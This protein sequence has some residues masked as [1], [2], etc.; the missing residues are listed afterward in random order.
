MKW[1]SS[2]L[3]NRSQICSISGSLSEPLQLCKGVPQGSILGPI[4]F[5]LYINNLPLT[6]SHVNVDI[7]ADDSTLWKYGSS[8]IQIQDDLQS[9]LNRAEAWF[10]LN[11]MVPNAKKTK[12]LLIG[13]HQKLHH[14]NMPSLELYMGKNLIAQAIDEKL[15][16]VML[17]QHFCWGNHIDYLLRKLNSR[18]F[19]LRRAK[20]YLTISCRIL[21]YNTLVKP[22]ILEYLTISR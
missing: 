9:S 13:T 1:F 12:L 5:S 16:G 17:D 7:Y 19:L 6:V 14:I 10:V 18:F 4:L 21:L 20:G 8:Y 22:I 2:Y 11:D 3:S 15:L